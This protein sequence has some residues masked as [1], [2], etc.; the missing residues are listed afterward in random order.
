MPLGADVAAPAGFLNYCSRAPNECAE[1]SRHVGAGGMT[2]TQA[3]QTYWASVFNNKSQRHPGPPAAISEAP[4]YAPLPDQQRRTPSLGGTALNVARTDVQPSS[5]Q[6]AAIVATNV[7]INRD[8]RS[9][10]DVELFGEPDRWTHPVARGP[11][12][13]GDC[14]D[15][16][17]AKR[18]ALLAQGVPSAALSI[19]L[20]TTPAGERHAVLLVNTA[21][22]EY[23]LD[24]LDQRVEHW[25]R[26]RL[27][28]MERQYPGEPLRWVRAATN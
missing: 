26:S 7:R 4:R 22:G 15:F 11:H 3:N 10:S 5:Y 21:G 18:S 9:R 27:R 25:S 1:E 6:W 8:V 24:N 20:A 28:W 13:A 16:V 12:L 14:E 17:L 2:L 19:A 23:V